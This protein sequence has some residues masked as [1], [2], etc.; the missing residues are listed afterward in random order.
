F[1]A[2]KLAAN[3]KQQYAFISGGIDDNLI[4]SDAVFQRKSSYF[5]F[6]NRAQNKIITNAF[7]S[8]RENIIYR[9]PY[10]DMLYKIDFTNKPMPYKF[11]DYSDKQLLID[12]NITENDLA[13]S[14][15]LYDYC[16]TRDIL[17]N[18]K[19]NF[20]I[21]IYQDVPWVYIDNKQEEQSSK[22][23]KYSN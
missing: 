20:V 1:N 21:F 19:Y 22:L 8:I 11:I 23:F 13:N 5:P 15:F 9:R 6:K 16:I 2:V 4:F 7:Y 3:S 18:E 12:D 14:A 10:D 17:E